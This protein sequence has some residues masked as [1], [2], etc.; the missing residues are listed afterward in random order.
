MLTMIKKRNKN[1]KIDFNKT[2]KIAM[3]KYVSIAIALKN[4][5]KTR[6]LNFKTS[7]IES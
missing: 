4:T 2:N 3:R 6:K 7:L 5:R 1:Q